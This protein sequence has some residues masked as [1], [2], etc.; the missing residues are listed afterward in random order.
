MNDETPKFRPKALSKA[1]LE[2]PMEPRWKVMGPDEAKRLHAAALAQHHRF[3]PFGPR[4]RKRFATITIGTSVAFIVLGWLMVSGTMRVFLPFGG[5]GLA[6]GAVVAILRPY[7]FL[8]GALYALA[9]LVA[10]LMMHTPLLLAMLA[11]MG[12][13]C[14]GI[15]TGRVEEGKALDGE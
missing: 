7:D 12:F 5:V 10:A 14:I 15:M 11:A 9:A 4:L 8:A 13:Y 1:S 2:A 6:L 3:N